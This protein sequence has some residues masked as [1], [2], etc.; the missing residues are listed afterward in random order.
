MLSDFEL[1]RFYPVLDTAFL[2]ARIIDVSL[3]AEAL[4][5]AGVKIL[6]YRHKG[7]WTDRHFSEAKLI[8]E[9]CSQAGVLFVL[10]DRAD[11]AAILGCA[12]HVGQDDLPPLAVRKIVPD[13][14]IGFSTHNGFQLERGNSEPVQYLSL[15]PIFSTASKANPDPVVRVSGLHALR[16]L[17][18]KPICAIGGITLAN[19]PEV[20][21]AGADSVAIISGLVRRSRAR[22]ELK[23]LA[24]EWLSVVAT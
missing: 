18:K 6:Q 20:L 1:P 2:A 24:E 14:V 23:Q 17:T 13:A 8:A 7:A 16:P 12:L 4:L 22:P 5:D 11:Y 9:L 15:G 3:A 21:D 19:A 10:N